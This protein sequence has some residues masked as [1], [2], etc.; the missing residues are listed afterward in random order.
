MISVNLNYSYRSFLLTS[1]IFGCFILILYSIKLRGSQVV[2]E[3]FA[4]DVELISEEFMEEELKEENLELTEI[5]TNRAYNEAEKYISKTE[6]FNRENSE[7]T[8]KKLHEID[9]AI[10][11]SKNGKQSFEESIKQPERDLKSNK[12]SNIQ[13]SSAKGVNKQTTISYMLKDRTHIYLPNPVYT[14][15]GSGK[16]VINIEVDALGSVRKTTFNKNASTTA[17]QCLI[18]AAV[19]YASEAKFT[20]NAS[21]Q[22]QLGS[23]T[24]NFP[25]QD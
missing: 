21:R 25:G 13:N 24:F 17:N 9:K 23:I 10:L 5:E 11:R 19:S 12:Y 20:S 2:Q 1:L 15:Y 18:D 6:T 8:E 16:V 3:D 14:C 7:V 4:Y 22:K